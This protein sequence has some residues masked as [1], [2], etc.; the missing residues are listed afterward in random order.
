MKYHYI[1]NCMKNNQDKSG[2]NPC[3]KQKFNLTTVPKYG[4][5]VKDYFQSKFYYEK[6]NI[7][8]S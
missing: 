6:V 8:Y 3:S 4:K 7:V 5:V 2:E 1:N